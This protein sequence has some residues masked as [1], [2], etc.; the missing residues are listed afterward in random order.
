MACGLVPVVPAVGNVCDAVTDGESGIVLDERTA[1]VRDRD[2]SARR[3]HL[4]AAVGSR[5][6]RQRPIFGRTRRRGSGGG[7]ADAAGVVSAR[8][9]SHIPRYIVLRDT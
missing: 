6:S 3:R 5:A 2:R 4:R 9:A 1:D 8:V 7:V